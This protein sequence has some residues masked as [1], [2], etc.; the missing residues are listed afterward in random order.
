MS[1]IRYDSVVPLVTE[2][3]VCHRRA[4]AKLQES[5]K[6]HAEGDIPPELVPTLTAG[7]DAEL[8]YLVHEE[9]RTPL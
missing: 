1:Q 2:D 6:E 5:R 3:L 7:S 9:E 4:K 8:Y